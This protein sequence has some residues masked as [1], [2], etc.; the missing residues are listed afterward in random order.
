MGRGASLLLN[1]PVDRRGRI[2]E[3]DVKSLVEFRRLLNTTFAMDIARGARVETGNVRGESKRFSAA[4]VV[5]A[6]R[7]TYWATE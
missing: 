4:N 3:N 5:D 7:D 1:L 2:H 6:R